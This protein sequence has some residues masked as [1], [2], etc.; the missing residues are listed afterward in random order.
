MTSLRERV[1]LGLPEKL[2]RMECL[3]QG[4][5]GEAPKRLW[6]SLRPR[7]A[8]LREVRC[9]RRVRGALPPNARRE[10]AE[11]ARIAGPVFLEQLMVFLISVVSSIFCGHLGKVELDAVTLALSV[12]NVI[13]ISVGTGLASACDTLVSQTFGAKNMKRIGIIL[14][15]AILILLLCC[16]P[17]WAIFIN[18][19]QILLLSKQDPEVSKLAQVYVM[20]FL[21]ALPAAFLYQLQTRYLRSQGITMP[22]V[23]TGIA[24]NIINVGMNALFLYALNLGVQGS[25]W[26]NT[27]SQFTQAFLLFLY[28]WWKKI[29]VETWGGWSAECFQ[30]WGTFIQLAVPSLLMVCIEW[31]TF[32]VGTFLTGMINMTTL[33]AQAVIYELSSAAYMVPL[34]LG[35]AA[36]FRVGH[37][38][39]AGSIDKAWQAAVTALLYTGICAIAVAVI[40]A[41]LKNV[42]AYVFT[43][44]K[45]IVT[46]VSQLMPIFIPFHLFDAMAATCSG[47]L[48]GLGKQKMGA[49]L[50]AVGYYVIGFPM[51]VSLMFATKLGIVGLWS[52]LIACVFFQSLFYFIYILKTSWNQAAEQAQIRA[53]MKGTSHSENAGLPGLES[54][55]FTELIFPDTISSESQTDELMSQCSVSTV[56]E[57]LTVKQLAFRRGIAFAAALGTLIAGIVIRHSTATLVMAYSLAVCEIA[58]DVELGEWSEKDYGAS[59][60][61]WLLASGTV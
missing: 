55:G 14:Q 56:G 37:A 44:D 39:G 22:Q 47:I 59:H 33:G 29:H 5:P 60:W 10:A 50:N 25:A 48:R 40:F 6:P 28:V 61:H 51:G 49:I 20:I 12:V 18:I 42:V 36:S 1:Q 19:E 35:M 32:E 8:A 15:R 9:L 3:A 52:G 38:L 45:D 34:S 13:G 7:L 54:E 11:L 53:G 30:E 43:S 23:I 41:A 4:P 57:L 24:A 46:M 26:A 16:F 21:P 27:T 2:S 58:M 17:C 31:W